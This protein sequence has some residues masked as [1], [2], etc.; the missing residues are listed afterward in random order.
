M[1]EQKAEACEMRVRGQWVTIPLDDALDKY[2]AS[3]EKRCIEC[4]GAVRAHR[5]GDNGM[6]AHFEH[7]DKHEGCSRGNYFNGT[8]MPHRKALK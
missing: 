4:H 1:E 8:K 5:E 6:R 3:R 7:L 2:D